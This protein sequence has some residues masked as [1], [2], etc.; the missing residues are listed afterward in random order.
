MLPQGVQRDDAARKAN[1]V[2]CS[3]LS[4]GITFPINILFGIP[5][6]ASIAASVLGGT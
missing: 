6:Y 5:L 4:L 2:T 3:G 1:P